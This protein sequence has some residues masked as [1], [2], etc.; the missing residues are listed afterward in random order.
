LGRALS[1]SQYKLSKCSDCGKVLGYSNINVKL[2][3]PER[4]MHLGSG[5][6]LKKIEK[7]AFCVECFQK[8]TTAGSKNSGIDIH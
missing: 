5:G 7:T 2:F 1:A 3:P 8:R 6:P 4:L